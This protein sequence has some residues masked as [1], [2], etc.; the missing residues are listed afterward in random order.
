MI[1]TVLTP[2]FLRIMSRFVPTNALD[3]CLGTASSPGRGSQ[4]SQNAAPQ[5]PSTANAG[6][7]VIVISDTAS[8]GYHFDVG[9]LLARNRFWDRTGSGLG[10]VKREHV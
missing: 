3:R 2:L 5:V 1:T 4:P 10:R 8:K 6:T 7:I 9:R